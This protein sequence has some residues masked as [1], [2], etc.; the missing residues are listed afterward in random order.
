MIVAWLP[1]KNRESFNQ[2]LLVNER[3]QTVLVMR[4][5]EKWFRS[6]HMA[7]TA[8]VSC[9]LQEW[10]G[11]KKQLSKIKIHLSPSISKNNMHFQKHKPQGNNVASIKMCVIFQK[12]QGFPFLSSETKPHCSACFSLITTWASLVSKILQTRETLKLNKCNTYTP[13]YLPCKNKWPFRNHQKKMVKH[14]DLQGHQALV[15]F[16]V[17]HDWDI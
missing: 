3:I 9:M 5:I 6:L 16:D 4:K 12:K 11:M 7:P 15:W 2:L 14:P 1:K 17:T 13:I 10:Y 8:Y